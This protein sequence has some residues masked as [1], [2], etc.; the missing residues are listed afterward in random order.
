M[1][2]I[3]ICGP[4]ANE[5]IVTLD[6]HVK[7]S[8]VLKNLNSSIRFN[9]EL[10]D[11]ATT[12]K[13]LKA[14][15]R[16]PIEVEENS[17]SSNM[18]FS[19]GAWCHVVK[20]S[21]TYWNDVKGEKTC[22]IGDYSIKVGGV[23]AGKEIKGKHVNTKIVFFADREKILCHLYNTTQLIHCIIFETILCC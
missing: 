5:E 21:I 17:T 22:K 12:A 15:K 16:I 13:L 3:K 11:K 18:V 10:D 4:S 6:D 20:P 14:A 8:E 1:S 19:A 23:K 2:P 9:Y 7:S